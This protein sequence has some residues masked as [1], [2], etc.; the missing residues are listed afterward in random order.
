MTDALPPLK[1]TLDVLVLKALS[2]GAKHGFEVTCWIEARSGGE[3]AVEDSALYQALY[4]LE[5]RDLIEAAW[6]V[7]ENNRRARYYVLTVAGVAFL[8]EEAE[9]MARYAAALTLLLGAD[10]AAG[11][12]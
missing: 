8:E 4:R 3:L 2:E 10:G 12:S 11:G 9:R 7:T 6:G 1:G 5:G